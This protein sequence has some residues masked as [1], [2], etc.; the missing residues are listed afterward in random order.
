MPVWPIG[1]NISTT[2]MHPITTRSL[3]AVG[4]FLGC[5]CPPRFAQSVVRCVLGPYRQGKC[6]M[7]NETYDLWGGQLT[8][9]DTR[10]HSSFWV[11]LFFLGLV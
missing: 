3:G 8:R 6:T 10:R 1:P 2:Y 9:R 7:H 11:P 5:P 4:C